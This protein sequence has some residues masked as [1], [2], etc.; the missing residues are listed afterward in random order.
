[1]K[2]AGKIFT[3]YEVKFMLILLELEN[4][5]LSLAF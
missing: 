4:C 3:Y 1:M 2:S 5:C